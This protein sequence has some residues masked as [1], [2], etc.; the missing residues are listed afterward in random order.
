MPI[1]HFIR[2]NIGWLIMAIINIPQTIPV[3]VGH[4]LATMT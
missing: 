3:P 4:K 2:Q 1:F